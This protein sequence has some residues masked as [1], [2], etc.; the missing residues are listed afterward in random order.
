MVKVFVRAGLDHVLSSCFRDNG[1]PNRFIKRS[2]TILDGYKYV[3]E[4]FSKD[5]ETSGL[6]EAYEIYQNI[7]NIEKTTL[8]SI[9]YNQ[10][11]RDR[12][13]ELLS[14]NLDPDEK[15]EDYTNNPD[16]ECTDLFGQIETE[17]E[18][19]GGSGVNSRESTIKKLNKKINLLEDLIFDLMWDCFVQFGIHNPY[20]PK[21]PKTKV[22]SNRKFLKLVEQSYINMHNEKD[23][24]DRLNLDSIN[25]EDN[26][27]FG[28][29]AVLDD[30]ERLTEC[31]A[32]KLQMRIQSKEFR[33]YLDENVIAFVD[34]SMNFDLLDDNMES[35]RQQ[36]DE[37]ESVSTVE[38]RPR[39]N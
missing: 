31:L 38:E 35:D 7:L 12:V 14:L 27:S 18:L 8:K 6:L 11:L 26:V 19:G 4:D 1:K 20:I 37:L 16:L 21:Y 29:K 30:L 9:S 36:D 34:N 17:V 23:R 3:N 25:V 22:M 2:F 15:I 28:L 5:I 33:R 10:G 32:H 13:I 39:T 24:Y